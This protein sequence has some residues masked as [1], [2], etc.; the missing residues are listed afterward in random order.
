MIIFDTEYTAW[1][2]SMESGWSRPGEYKEIIQI[3]AI[4]IN[5]EF[6]IQDSFEVFVKP[7]INP[8]L[9]D[10]IKNLTRI[11]QD[12]LE[13]EGCDLLVALD[14]FKMFCEEDVDSI[15]ISNGGD[16]NII[17]ENLRIRGLNY[18]FDRLI[19]SDIQPIFS[20]LIDSYS[21]VSIKEMAERLGIFGE[22]HSA[23]A[24]SMTLYKIIQKSGLADDYYQLVEKLA[25]RNIQIN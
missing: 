9:S 7:V 14:K 24:D 11:N 22:H 1:P 4:K 2:G 19:F 6:E 20:E 12:I 15:A 18:S 23:I 10:Y 5:R 13:S 21:H 17:S 25:S 3:G 8:L 16:Q